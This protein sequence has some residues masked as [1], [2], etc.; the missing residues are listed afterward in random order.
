M[1]SILS[2]WADRLYNTTGFDKKNGNSF[3]NPVFL[4]LAATLALWMLLAYSNHFSN[5]FHFDDSHTIE[6]NNAIKEIN[7]RS[8]FTDTSTFSAL[9]TNQTYRPYTTLEN[10]IDYK[11]AG[12][13]HP[14]VFHIHIFLS[15]VLTCLVLC[16]FT[17]KLLDR[18]DYSAHNSFWGLLVAT[19]FGLLC[20]NAETVNYIIQR[21]EIISGLYVLLGLSFFLTGGRW[22]KNYIYL[23]FPFIGFFAK[24]MA[25]VF[26]PVLLLYFLIFEEEVD[27]LHFYRGTEFKKCLRSFTK[28]GPAFILTIAFYIFYSS[29]LPET[30]DPGG[31]D[32]FK[33]LITQP[34][35]MLHYIGTYFV[36]YNLSADS[37]WT[38]YDSI[39]DYRAILGILGVLV[40]AYLALRASKNKSTK[41]FSF[42]MLWFF[43]T[44]LPSSS[45]I[46]FAE[47][48]NDH[49]SFIP[50]MGLTIAFV[51]GTK[52]LLDTYLP[53]VWT[54]KNGPT[55]LL[56]FLVLFLSANA[57]GVYQ[58]NKVWKDDLSL[59]K[60]V[61]LKSPGNGRGLMNYG[62]ALMARADYADAEKC[63][64]KALVIN[65]N[66]GTLH[67]NL[68]ILKGATGNPTEAEFHFKRAIELN[69]DNH[70]SW[71]YYG[72]FLSEAGRYEEAI[73]SL[74]KGVDIS[75]NFSNIKEL[76][77]KAYHGNRDWEQLHL[78]SS[79]ILESSPNDP[80]AKKYSDIARDKKSMAD[81]LEAEIAAAP[82]AE[83]YLDLSLRF[84]NE[85][86]YEK[87]ISSANKALE[88]RPE[89]AEAHN[90]IGIAYFYLKEYQEAI[91]AYEKA[92]QLKPGYQLA[93]NNL[94]QVR[95][96]LNKPNVSALS[97][98]NLRASNDFINRSLGYYNEGRYKEAIE[99]ARN[100]IAIRPNANAYNNICSAYNQLGQYDQ[101]IEACREALK[102]EA[103]HTL[104]K[105]N[106]NFALQQKQKSNN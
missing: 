28:A 6:D 80:S 32:R 90:N 102:L 105:G 84:F 21:A 104:A 34:M 64:E 97:I 79:R 81:M 60:D 57:Y 35:V 106:L 73:G 69:A 54:S 71:Y 23:L 47:V 55:A 36:P 99:A 72:K 53:N 13:L 50:Y 49:R 45:F 51:F 20:A 89:Y 62:L 43:I 67:I 101:A 63:F 42:G 74:E 27:L 92:L 88:L 8:F 85:G 38:V 76:L 19:I 46:A 30:F 86:N 15:F 40:L 82:T 2:K 52:H 1:T 22:R 26:A 91:K 44:L 9:T 41:L 12:G 68:G 65:P 70:S 56:L 5:G 87:C 100:S 95:A 29:M 103:E 98:A 10:A 31:L 39:L 16:F 17:K 7:V 61:T 58:R 11:L 14:Q 24:E 37:D 4:V 93:Q 18:L 78:F 3:K 48:M 59:W 66:Y 75:P 83:K 25:F 94:S 77:M 96:E 33:Y